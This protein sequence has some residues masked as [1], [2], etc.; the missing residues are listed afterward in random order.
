MNGFPKDMNFDFHFDSDD[1]MKNFD[2]NINTEDDGK[3]VIIKKQGGNI[4][5]INESD[6][7]VSTTESESDNG[8]TKTKTKTI[9]I[10]D[11]KAKT[12]KKV[13]VT[14]SVVVI[15]M[16]DENSEKS[17]KRMSKE[18]SSFNFYP[19]PSDGNFVLDMELNSKEDASIRIVDMN[20]KEV[21]NEKF[22]GSGKKTKSINLGNN[23]KGTFIVTIKQG[24]K[25]SNKKI[26]IE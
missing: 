19:N 1:M 9:V 5:I 16:E 10:K 7:N 18:E 21:Y 12:K 4:I 6:D 14:T 25:T 20:G 3:T 13:I 26:I 15:D 22:S 24:K 23:K 8:K 11:D 17:D 2:F